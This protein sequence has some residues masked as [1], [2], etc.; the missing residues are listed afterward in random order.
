MSRR[1]MK[2]ARKVSLDATINQAL[3][4]TVDAR[5]VTALTVG[6][7]GVIVGASLAFGTAPAMAAETN[8][9]DSH[10]S[11][12]KQQS[13]EDIYDFD[14]DAIGNQSDTDATDNQSGKESQDL[15]LFNDDLDLSDLNLTEDEDNAQNASQSTASDE[16]KSNEEKQSIK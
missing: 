6:A 14:V 13:A 7:A 2:H 3:A 9:L 11:A 15:D 16:T 8:A 12:E 1:S 5:K 10:S 4:K